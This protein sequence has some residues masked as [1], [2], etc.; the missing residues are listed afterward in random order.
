MKRK[1]LF[2]ALIIALVAG[3]IGGGTM[4]WFTAKAEVE[5]TFTA[6]TVMINPGEAIVSGDLD[7]GNWN[8]GD[9][10][11]LT[12]EIHNS[13]SKDTYIRIKNG[14]KHGNETAMVRMNDDPWDL[15]HL[16]P[17]HPWFTYITYIEYVPENGQ[18]TFFFYAGQTQRVG[19]VDVNK[20]ND[21]LRIRIRLDEGFE[22]SKSDVNVDNDQDNF[23]DA[24]PKPW[25]F[26]RWPHNA[27]HIPYATE[28]VYDI[29]W[30]SEWALNEKLYIGVH[31]DVWGMFGA[32]DENGLLQKGYWEFDW[33]WLW[34]NWYAL[35]FTE[36]G[37]ETLN[38]A[39]FGEVPVSFEDIQGYP[40]WQAFKQ[41]VEG[42]PSPV[43][44][45]LCDNSSY[46]ELADD[47]YYYYTGPPIKYCERVSFC[48][49]VCFDI[50][51]PNVFQKAVFRLA[52]PVEAVQAS[53]DAPYYVWGT[54]RYR[55]PD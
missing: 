6:G 38:A 51:A 36:L 30:N 9:C 28:F 44:I 27:Q 18:D 22:M 55:T 33:E 45:Q 25:A 5:N 15:T 17:G 34:E 7:I 16:Y 54:T 19:E 40:E 43:T 8:P 23:F 24:F 48:L 41:I 1:I 29:P 20:V 47:D 26:G 50:K 12:W 11:E 32:S 14:L 4:A 37:F 52:L 46:W 2:V 42:L 31:A 10:T 53:N 21:F 13:G 39:Y 3:L 49:K 35:C